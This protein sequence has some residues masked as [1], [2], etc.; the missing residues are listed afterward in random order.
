M[1][2][3]QK[4]SPE[5]NK[6]AADQKPESREESFAIIS[7]GLLSISGKN[8]N[9]FFFWTNLKFPFSLSSSTKRPTKIFDFKFHEFFQPA[10]KTTTSVWFG[11]RAREK[12]RKSNWRLRLNRKQKTFQLQTRSNA[13]FTFNYWSLSCFIF[14]STM[15]VTGFQAQEGKQQFLYT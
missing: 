4:N 14:F 9:R 15:I 7:R 6:K 12:K 11:T 8:I 5:K 10:N 13:N 3:Q 2:G 1:S